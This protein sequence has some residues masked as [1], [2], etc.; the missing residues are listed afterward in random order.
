MLNESIGWN[1][2]TTYAT[3]KTC[4]EKG[5]IQREEPHYLCSAR[6]NKS[7]VQKGAT[8]ELIDKL[9]DGSKDHLFAALINKNSLTER[10][11]Q[12][13]LALVEELK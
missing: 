9:Y 11:I 3:I 1:K 2:N 10:E 8:I 13:L 7:D 4:I 6:I 12:E 5:F